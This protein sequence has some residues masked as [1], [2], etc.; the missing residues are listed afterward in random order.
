MKDIYKVTIH[1]MTLESR[2][3]RHLLARAVSEKRN[4]DQRLRFLPPVGPMIVSGL[5]QVLLAASA[6]QN[7]RRAV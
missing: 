5:G 7:R 2:N 3:L 4:M 6:V 1:G